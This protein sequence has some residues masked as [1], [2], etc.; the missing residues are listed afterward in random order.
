MA[1]IKGDSMVD[2]D[3]HFQIKVGSENETR[4]IQ[5]RSKPHPNPL[6]D[7]TIPVIEDITTRMWR[8]YFWNEDY[9][10]IETDKKQDTIDF[11]EQLSSRSMMAIQS[12]S[13]S[14]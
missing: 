7:G 6:V 4:R 8:V 13:T 11:T 1:I 14:I 10:V 3:G 12:S 2:I 5:T 9:L